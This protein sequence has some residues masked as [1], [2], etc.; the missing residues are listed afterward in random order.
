MTAIHDDPRREESIAS[1]GPV[2]IRHTYQPSSAHRSLTRALV[3]SSPTTAQLTVHSIEGPPPD[4][5]LPAPVS[6]AELDGRTFVPALGATRW[7]ITWDPFSG[8]VRVFDRASSTGVFAT[9]GPPEDWEHAA[10]FRAFLHWTAAAR[11]AAMVHASTVGTSAGMALVVGPG[12]T[13]KSTTTL[14]A[15]S[16]GLD[17]CGDDYVWVERDGGSLNVRSVY[18]TIKVKPGTPAD[19]LPSATSHPIESG[20]KAVYW[21]AE[22]HRDRV[23]AEAPLIA[24]GT[25]SSHSSSVSRGTLLAAVGPST[26]LQMPYD[27]HD[28][29]AVLRI[30]VQ[31][32]P[33]YVWPRD[34]DL[35][36]LA[37][38]IARDVGAAT[39]ARG[40]T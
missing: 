11:G 22:A 40:P 19:L 21:F 20:S 6:R 28:T 36:G 27:Q 5:L 39:S 34:G 30:A 1:A 8:V 15:L 13:G 9:H 31:R 12:G 7:R 17:T 33:V 2:S 32:L 29:L 24:M 35:R 4:L 16:Y 23:V 10:P 38:A 3:G 25:L 37:T 18:G 14:V 26:V